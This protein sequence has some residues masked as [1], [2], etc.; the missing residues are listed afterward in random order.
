MTE[1]AATDPKGRAFGPLRI[2]GLVLIVAAAG[3]LY[4][5]F[6]LDT[7]VEQQPTLAEASALIAA[8]VEPQVRQVADADLASR[9][10]LLG[11]SGAAALVAGV[12]LVARRR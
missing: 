11:M 2:L 4:D 6:R 7:T 1:T 12:V 8:G 3:T 10:L 9:Q 5:A